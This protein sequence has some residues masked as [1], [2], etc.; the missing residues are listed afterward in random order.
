M[1]SNNLKDRSI[2]GAVNT[3]EDTSYLSPK[4]AHL[5]IIAFYG[6]LAAIV[7]FAIP[8][9]TVEVWHK[10]LLVLVICVLGGFRLMDAVMRGSFRI[11]GTPLLL[12]LAGI[13]SLA[14]IQI[15][16]WSGHGG[17]VSTDVYETRSFILV[18]SGLLVAGEMLF[19]YTSTERRLKCLVA[20]VIVV[21]AGSAIFGILRDVFLDAQNGLLSG[22]LL[23]DQGYAQFIN[24]NHFAFLMEMVFGLMLGLL[25]KGEMSERARFFGWMLSAVVLYSLI[26]SNS[27]GGL[28]GLLGLSLFGAFMH[29]ATWR[30]PRE[31]APGRSR[32]YFRGSWIRRVLLASGLGA[33]VFGLIIVIIAFVGGDAVVSRIEKIQGE[34][35]TVN[36]GKINRSAIWNATVELIEERPVF[37]AGF[38]GYAAAITK[39]D[40]TGGMLSL[41]Q[42]HNDYLEVLANGGVAGFALFVVFGVIVALRASRNLMSRDPI[43]RASCFG[44][45]IGIFGVL[46]HSFVDFG[47][48]ILINALVFTVLIVIATV[49]I[50]ET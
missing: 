36:T 30:D 28:I 20:L 3:V 31:T 4:S 32:R 1:L 17:F 19:F 24:R 46:V 15:V 16:P 18:F 42:A 49:R 10:S 6:L 14:L 8:Y 22:Y 9:G 41:Q 44:A 29:F 43:V 25:I 37:G 12:P 39:F 27:R 34:V 13:L 23:P 50:R 11:A 2:E 35:E 38:G 21:G 5:G 45:S 33:L 47:L 26:S 48:H 7:V 40:S